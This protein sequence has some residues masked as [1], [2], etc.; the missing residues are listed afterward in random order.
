MLEDE[1]ARKA[2]RTICTMRLT[3]CAKHIAWQLLV[4]LGVSLGICSRR[5]RQMRPDVDDGRLPHRRRGDIRYGRLGQTIK[6]GVGPLSRMRG[7]RSS[8]SGGIVLRDWG[9]GER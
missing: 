4:L 2:L 6:Q 7:S 5:Q 3:V 9:M 1:S 8:W